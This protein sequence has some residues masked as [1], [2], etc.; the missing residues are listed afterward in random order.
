MSAIDEIRRSKQISL[1]TYR[2]DGTGVATPV[3]HV[4]DGDELFVVSEA[5][6]WK[7][8]RIRNDGRVEVTASDFRGRTAP[9]A[10]TV[11]GT[12]RLLDE[13]GTAAARRMLA[14]KYVTSRLGNWF[15]RL[16][17][18]RRPPLVAIAVTFTP[19]PPR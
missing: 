13:A 4:M 10:T 14:R 6:S 7:V 17:H 9:G 15:A 11:T 2:R 18:L 8:K 16:L 1:V 3:W 12:A 19:A 5:K